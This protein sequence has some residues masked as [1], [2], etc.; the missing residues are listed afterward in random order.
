[1]TTSDTSKRHLAIDYERVAEL[2][3]RWSI[4]QLSLFGSILR[5]DFRPDSDVDVLLTFSPDA[6]WTLLDITRLQDEL[7]LILGRSV[8]V[9]EEKSLKNPFR[10]RE[11]LRTRQVL[12]AA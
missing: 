1:L 8:D 9:V 3:Q 11:I 7:S 4:T 2:C 6:R 5:P 10:R 12:Y